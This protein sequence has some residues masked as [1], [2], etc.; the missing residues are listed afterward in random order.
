MVE[1]RP[2]I[3][4]LIPGGDALRPQSVAIRNLAQ[5]LR[6]ALVVM[7]V[8][9]GVAWVKPGADGGQSVIGSPAVRRR[10]STDRKGGVCPDASVCVFA[11][12]LG[13]I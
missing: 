13:K 12:A 3:G 7:P 4:A 2:R 8:A 6:D 5:H 9:I 11:D 1:I 10:K